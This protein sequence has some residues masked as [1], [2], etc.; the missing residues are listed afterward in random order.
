MQNFST[1][2]LNGVLH[3][4]SPPVSPLC[5]CALRSLDS[6]STSQA[7]A[8][9]LTSS[10]HSS[11]EGNTSVLWPVALISSNPQ[12]YRQL[13]RSYKGTVTI[14]KCFSKGAYTDGHS[15]FLRVRVQCLQ[16]PAHL[17]DRYAASCERR[18]IQ[19]VARYCPSGQQ[20]LKNICCFIHLLCQQG[21][22]LMNFEE[23]WHSLKLPKKYEVHKTR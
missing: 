15:P 17:E 13:A 7:V 9:T 14:F 1:E 23:C 19:R 5:H 12:A 4:H 6:S 3:P 18:G 20:N 10:A 21:L 8:H 22:K 16:L 2:L 11:H